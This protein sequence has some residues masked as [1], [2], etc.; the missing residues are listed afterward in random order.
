MQFKN[1]NKLLRNPKQWHTQ[2]KSLYKRR[3]AE[4]EVKVCEEI[5]KPGMHHRT[6][7]WYC[8][9]WFY[10]SQDLTFG[11]DVTRWECALELNGACSGD[12]SFEVWGLHLVVGLGEACPLPPPPPPPNFRVFPLDQFPCLHTVNM[13]FETQHNYNLVFSRI[14]G[15]SSTEI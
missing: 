14:I 7:S 5:K 12:Q 15:I 1:K 6:A 4:L 13:L 9:Y 3:P 2:W 8:G 10:T 11:L